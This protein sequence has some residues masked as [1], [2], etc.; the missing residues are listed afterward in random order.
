MFLTYINE[1]IG[2][3]ENNGIRVKDFA[4]D[5][6]LYLRITNDADVNK[7]QLALDSIQNW[8]SM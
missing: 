1:L 2:I 7:L 4:D 6:K 3:L 8:A 5:V